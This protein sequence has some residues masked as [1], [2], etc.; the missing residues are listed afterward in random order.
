MSG[1]FLLVTSA[2]FAYF[3]SVGLMLPVIARY[4]RDELGGSDVAV[5]A[6]ATAYG[7]AAI[8]CRPLLTVIAARYGARAMM[9][10]G[11]VLSTLVLAL[12]VRASSV[13]VLVVLRALIG[14]GEALLFV[15]AATI[16][17]DLSPP[18]RRAEAAS[19]FSVAVF[20][21]LGLGPFLGEWFA[22]GDRWS[23]SF[24]TA[25][26]WT[27]VA[28]LLALT[29]PYHRP[30]ASASAGRV[31]L[32]HPAGIAT[33]VV[34]AAAMVG[35]MGWAAFLPLRADE[36]GA[37]AGA[38]FAAYSGF[39]LV[40]RLVGA[41][42]PERVGLGRTSVI[43]VVVIAVALGLMAVLPGTGG[44]WVG[45]FVLGIGIAML[46]PSLMAITVNSVPEGERAAV[47][48]TFT[49]FFEVGAAVGGLL[50]GGVASVSSYQGAFG[51]GA[52]IALA[53]LVPLWFLVLGPR[54]ASSAAVAPSRAM[55]T[56]APTNTTSGP[57]AS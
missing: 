56:A 15:G 53:G 23:A 4:V 42:L 55:A 30:A 39:V 52:A 44:L 11:S 43:A 19:Y 35:Y 18:T 7:V 26:A 49:M 36:V 13:A 50:L 45:T 6:M 10:Q 46:Y 25:A 17:N 3:M 40:L 12:H 54:R 37:A 16:V 8:A 48:G 32:L 34:L 21:G 47:I 5:G 22:D 41:K 2:T 14:V 27:A 29:V 51:V 24:V 20:G 9:L 1:P 33:G 57:R 38:L 28:G 31:R